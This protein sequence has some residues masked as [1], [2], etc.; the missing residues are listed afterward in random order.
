MDE[1]HGAAAASLSLARLGEV[2]A[3]SCRL[4]SGVCSKG[5]RVL[6]RSNSPSQ[7]IVCIG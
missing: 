4:K 2:L 1:T 5:Q 3:G 7:M 6:L